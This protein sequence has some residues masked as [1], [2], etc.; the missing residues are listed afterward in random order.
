MAIHHCCGNSSGAN[1]SDRAILAIISLQIKRDQNRRFPGFERIRYVFTSEFT[2]KTVFPWLS[3]QR[4]GL[5]S[6]F[7]ATPVPRA[8][9]APG[10]PTPIML[11]PLVVILGNT[12]VTPR[13]NGRK[14]N[15]K[16]SQKNC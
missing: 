3:L 15:F 10:R 7:A 13:E 1:T 6:L 14:I 5:F 16:K 11:V 12:K 9:P 4:C 8:F 2:S